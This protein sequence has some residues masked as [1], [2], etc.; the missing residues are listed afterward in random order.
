MTNQPDVN[1]SEPL[2]YVVN[3]Q[4]LQSAKQWNNIE[5]QVDARDGEVIDDGNGNVLVRI[6]AWLPAGHIMTWAK[7]VDADIRV[8]SD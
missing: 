5:V 7:T 3:L 8:C 2:K 4:D 6:T 1:P